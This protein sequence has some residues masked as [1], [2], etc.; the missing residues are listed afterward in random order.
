[1]ATDASADSPRARV[2]LLAGQGFTLG[3]VTSWLLIA[4]STVFLDTYGS[5]LLPAT[6]VGAALAGVASSVGL[7]V[8]FRTRPLIAVTS[9]VLRGLAVG[10]LASWLLLWLGDASWMSFVLLVLV[11]V[12]VPAGFMFL[13]GQAG[14]LLDV[15][16]L[17]AMYARVIG[18][19]AFGFVVGSGVAPTSIAVLGRTEHLLAMAVAAVA[20]WLGLIAVARRR[21]AGELLATASEERDGGGP[22]LSALLRDRYVALIIAFQMLS[23]VESQWLDYLVYDRAA[24]RYDDSRDLA[25]FIS[26]F[27]AIT[28][29]ADILVLL[30]LAGLLLRRFGLRYGLSAN[31]AGVLLLIGA[32]LAASASQGAG[33]TVV[34]VLVVSTRAADLV[35][36]DGAA[37]ASLSA[38]YQVVPTRMRLAAQARVEG[39]AVPLA[40]GCSGIGILV[41]RWTVG[42]D[43]MV[44]PILT[45]VVVAT[46]AVVAMLVHRW[47]RR[48]LL[49]SL[50]YRTLDAAAL[51][52][53]DPHSLL[54]IDRLLESGDHAD[55]RLGLDALEQ[56]DHPTFPGRLAHLAGAAKP[57]VR[58]DALERLLRVDPILAAS[59]AR[60]VLLNGDQAVRA[61]CLHI[62]GAVPDPSDLERVAAHHDD[63]DPVVQVAAAAAMASIGDVDAQARVSELIAQRAAHADATVRTIAARTLAACSHTSKVDRS[64]LRSLLLDDA[65]VVVAAALDAVSWPDDADVL[66][67][68][69]CHLADRRAHANA[70]AA[71][72]RGADAVLPSIDGRLAAASD[73]RRVHVLLVR[74]ARLIGGPAAL[75]V[76]ERHVHHRDREVGLAVMAAV[77]SL[78]AGGTADDRPPAPI[79]ADLIHG[80]TILR[81]LVV[82]DK[83]DETGLLSTALRDELALVR[84]RVLAALSTRHGEEPLQRVAHQ[85]DQPDTRVHALALEWLDVT[86]AGPE[87]AVVKLLEPGLSDEERLRAVAGRIQP[88]RP[89]LGTVLV[90][91]VSDAD[92]RWRQPWLRACALFAALSVADGGLELVAD[93]GPPAHLDV[94][95]GDLDIV[96][97]TLLGVRE[98][99][100]QRHALLS[101]DLV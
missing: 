55:V 85:L 97:E 41:L 20:G 49:A 81:Y 33:A 98:R 96:T 67:L 88:P 65:P 12:V 14:M 82:I 53:D 16:T 21:F 35:L 89:D 32:L 45:G 17:K 48:N 62:L 8:A 38:A 2:A 6:Y 79:E 7:T 94:A 43:G 36:S 99:I 4:A 42:T 54:I 76:L 95:T 61:M 18:G 23:A 9:T 91:L 58:T 37:R 80:T 19:F 93:V 63:P 101:D 25:E 11:P 56:A 59:T 22:T 44:L 87:R 90:D 69:V 92:D 50:R 70:V 15:R 64:P 86:L 100:A 68:V 51:T 46:W 1:M 83:H 28:Y 3:L 10:L 74:A 77:G 71:L 24:Q 27:T 13:V 34:F 75:T 73:D 5:G 40:I 26:R 78:T 52:V 29:G 47:Y 39:L 30:M 72:V 84:R 57:S 66:D 31:P 60:R